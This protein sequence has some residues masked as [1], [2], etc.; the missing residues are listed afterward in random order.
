MSI[1][2]EA[3][4][5]ALFSSLLLR[6]GV[7]QKTDHLWPMFGVFIAVYCQQYC[8]KSTAIE[9]TFCNV[10]SSTEQLQGKR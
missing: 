1:N 7:Q 3:L 9:I 8:W 10:V 2:Y 5:Y 4:H 6:L